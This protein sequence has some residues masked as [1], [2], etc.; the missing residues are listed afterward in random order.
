MFYGS[1]GPFKPQDNGILEKSSFFLAA[2]PPQNIL[3]PTFCQN[4]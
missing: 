1:Y 2:Q 4:E 3:R